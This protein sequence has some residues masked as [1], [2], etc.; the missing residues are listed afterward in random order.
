MTLVGIESGLPGQYS[1]ALPLSQRVY[2]LTQVSKATKVEL[3]AATML[4][5]FKNSY[6]YFLNHLMDL[7]HIWYNDRY[8]SK[9]SISNILPS[10]LGHKGQKLGHKV[11]SYKNHEH[12]RGHSLNALFI[13]LCQNVYLS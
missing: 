6:M 4:K 5:F 7:V 12:F 3:S 11:K 8:R 1:N 2:S 9:V 10:P 13:K